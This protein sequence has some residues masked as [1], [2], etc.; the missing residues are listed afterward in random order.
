MQLKDKATVNDEILSRSKGAS[1]GRK[2]ERHR[3][4]FVRRSQATH[5]LPGMEG[6]KRRL[7]IACI[8]QPLLQR[9]RVNRSRANC[10]ATDTAGDKVHRY[11]LC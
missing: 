3:R 6:L 4:D 5:G 9:G 11:R 10:I 2:I 8:L 1:I 7:V